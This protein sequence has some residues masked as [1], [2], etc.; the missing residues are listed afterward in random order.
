MTLATR[1]VSLA[2]DAQER[3][4]PREMERHCAIADRISALLGQFEEE[5]DLPDQ[6]PAT[7]I[8]E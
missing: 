8:A 7:A 4:W 3:G 1:L 2:E 5:T 6:R